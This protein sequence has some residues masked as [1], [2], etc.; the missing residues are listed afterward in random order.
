MLVSITE[1]FSGCI[2]IV[3]ASF[4]FEQLLVNVT[5]IKQRTGK[6]EIGHEG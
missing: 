4:A 1:L 2:V 6:S 3:I 5:S